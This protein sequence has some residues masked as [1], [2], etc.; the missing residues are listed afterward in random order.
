MAKSP[1]RR[2]FRLP[3]VNVR[4]IGAKNA[5]WS[6][7]YHRAMTTS[8][9]NF[10]AALMAIYLLNNLLFASL[11][12][13]DPNSVAEAG[14]PRLL[15]LFFFSVESFTTVGF[16]AMH[17]ADIWG[18]MVFSLE[19]FVAITQL[20]TLTGLIFARFSKPRA[21]IIFADHPIIAVHDGQPNLMIRTANARHNFISD[22]TAQLWLVR[23]ENNK[24]GQTF[25]RFH[26]LPLVR[27]QNPSFALSW[28][29]FHVIDEAS[30]LDGL[31]AKDLAA[32]N[33]MFILTIKGIDE[34]SSQELRARKNYGHSEILWGY[35]YAD[36]LTT[37]KN[38]DLTLDYRKFNHTVAA[39]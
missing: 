34:T 11:Y 21:R 14:E 15:N 5:L 13:I 39:D 28:T 3:N 1:R 33:Y 6:D 31:T 23:S 22:A 20:A 24:E 10:V 7:L 4:T 29:L 12:Y 25:R 27:Q 30:L 36:I 38:G 35:R 16:G 17:P 18:H 19:G 32:K 9:Y 26:E 37:E 2:T 8:L